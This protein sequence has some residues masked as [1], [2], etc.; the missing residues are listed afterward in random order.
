M[1]ISEMYISEWGIFESLWLR[2]GANINQR[3]RWTLKTKKKE[4]KRKKN[5][6]TKGKMKIGINFYDSVR[7]GHTRY[8]TLVQHAIVITIIV[9]LIVENGEF[10]FITSAT[11]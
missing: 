5:G 11:L 10:F 6:K 7:R 8:N 2:S 3:E 4:K 9:I 1:Y